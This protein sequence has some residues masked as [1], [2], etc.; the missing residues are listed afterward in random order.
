M[1]EHVLGIKMNE[2]VVAA[3]VAKAREQRLTPLREEAPALERETVDESDLAPREQAR[4]L[5]LLIE[6]VGYDGRDSTVTVTFRPPG[7]EALCRKAGLNRQEV[8]R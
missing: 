4:S 2:Q 3:T 7:I 6:R 1:V 8:M 5:R